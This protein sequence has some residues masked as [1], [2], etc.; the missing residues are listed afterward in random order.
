MHAYTLNTHTHDKCVC[1]TTLHCTAPHAHA[2][3]LP[4]PV[5]IFLLFCGLPFLSCTHVHIYICINTHTLSLSLLPT[6][7]YTHTLSLSHT[8]TRI[9]THSVTHCIYR[10]RRRRRRCSGCGCHSLCSHHLGTPAGGYAAARPACVCV[11][12]CVGMTTSFTCTHIFTHYLT[13]DSFSTVL[14]K[15]LR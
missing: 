6:H 5:L 10:G 12:E 8:H 3:L 2:P 7:A 15:Q 13:S 4:R 1:C 14:L 11:Y 9:H